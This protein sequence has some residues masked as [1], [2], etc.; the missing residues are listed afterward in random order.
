[1]AS[2][3]SLPEKIDS[4]IVER[5]M[6]CKTPKVI[7][8]CTNPKV[9]ANANRIYCGENSAQIIRDTRLHTELQFIVNQ[10][11]TYI[12]KKEIW[13]DGIDVES[14]GSIKKCTSTSAQSSM[15][16]MGRGAI[17]PVHKIVRHIL[18]SSEINE[19]KTI[20]VMSND[21]GVLAALLLSMRKLFDTQTPII[22]KTIYLANHTPKKE[23]YGT[24]VRVLLVVEL[25]RAL[26]M[27]YRNV[28]A[29]V[30]CACFLMTF[31]TCLNISKRDT[32][33]DILTMLSNLFTVLENG[34]DQ[35]GTFSTGNYQECILFAPISVTEPEIPQ[36]EAPTL[37]GFDIG[38]W[39]NF[40]MRCFPD[41]VDLNQ[42][43]QTEKSAVLFTQLAN[44]P[45]SFDFSVIPSIE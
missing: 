11:K 30:E 1:M 35:Y 17:F 21:T 33:S 42:E 27:E 34:F 31:S 28:Y 10:R 40:F 43:I 7:M 6:N 9:Y 22:Q 41:R 14:C 12:H 39:T 13:L 38:A 44:A 23:F 4:S 19:K 37:F 25:W 18:F 3:A 16:V 20:C 5:F 8:A 2:A 29:P 45:L 24:N 32:V 36:K 15:H 26:C